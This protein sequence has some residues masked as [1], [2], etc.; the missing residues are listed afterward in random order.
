VLTAEFGCPREQFV[1]DGD[2]RSP[3]EL[4]IE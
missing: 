3:T 4:S 1:L 2:P